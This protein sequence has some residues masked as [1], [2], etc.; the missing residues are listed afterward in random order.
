MTQ[1]QL[2]EQF[3]LASTYASQNGFE[4]LGVF[5]NSIDLEK[6]RLY[7]VYKPTMEKL[8]T[9]TSAFINS[10]PSSKYNIYA[11]HIV[12]FVKMLLHTRY[13]YKVS[14]ALALKENLVH[15]EYAFNTA[16]KDVIADTPLS[17][18]IKY[19]GTETKDFVLVAE[20]D[21][22]KYRL[23][24]F[25]DLSE[26]KFASDNLPE[27]LSLEKFYDEIRGVASANRTCFRYDP[28]PYRHSSPVII[29]YSTN[30]KNGRTV[31]NIQEFK[32]WLDMAVKDLQSG[33]TGGYAPLTTT[34]RKLRRF[35]TTLSKYAVEYKEESLLLAIN[36]LLS[37]KDLELY[38]A[39][40]EFVEEF[41]PD[42][43]TTTPVQ[44]SNV[45]EQLYSDIMHKIYFS[46]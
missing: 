31:E 35:L 14:Y 11:I 28:T 9:E 30:G 19:I 43:H 22:M 23:G 5:T 3:Q 18:I 2:K 21:A 20:L 39:F 42:L 13:R 4:I 41:I 29:C 34:R 33:Q 6:N 10:I 38:F 45:T 12:D 24:Y 44:L 40:E 32:E 27:T 26:I 37:L 7:V 8:T 16:I 1:D 36:K 25:K 15:F 17:D 46:Y